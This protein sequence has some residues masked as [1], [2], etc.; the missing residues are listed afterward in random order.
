MIHDSVYPIKLRNA[1][2]IYQWR[3]QGGF[4]GFH[5]TALSHESTADYVAIVTELLE[6]TLWVLYAI[7]VA[8]VTNKTDC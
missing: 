7:V 2:S 4:H 6:L 3:I 1:T 5:G 8:F